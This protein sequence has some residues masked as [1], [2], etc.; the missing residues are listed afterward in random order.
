MCQSENIY[1]DKHKKH[2]GNIVICNFA[3]PN[4]VNV[5]HGF[6]PCFRQDGKSRCDIFGALYISIIRFFCLVKNVFCEIICHSVIIWCNCLV[7]KN[8][9]E[10]QIC[11]YLQYLSLICH[12]S[13]INWALCWIGLLLFVVCK[14][15]VAKKILLLSN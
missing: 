9:A 8:I 1:S 5:F 11:L 12:Y 7:Y 2:S 6:R 4:Y 14:Y 3:P 15:G 10:W 13:V